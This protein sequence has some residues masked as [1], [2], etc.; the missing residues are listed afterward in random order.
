MT[1]VFDAA[2]IGGGLA[3]CS[4]AITLAQ[5]GA[6]VLLLEAK[7]YPLHRVC[8]EF[9][10]PASANILSELGVLP[11]VEALHPALIDRAR[12]VAP[13]GF[14]WEADL[15]GAGLGL[16]RYALDALL[17]HEAERLGVCLHTETTVQDVEGDL[18][19]GFTLTARHDGQI[20][21]YQARVVIAAYGKRA[22]LD[23]VLNRPFLHR[24]IQYVGLK[25]HLRG[26][27]IE[28]RVELYPFPGGYC[29]L[30]Q[31]E[32]GCT[33]VC[34]LVRQDV[35]Q[36]QGAGDISAFIEWMSGQNPALGAWLARAEVVHP[37]WF[38][39][40]QISFQR[41]AALEGDLLMTGD[42]AG[43]I[44]PLAGDG[45]EMA[46]HGGRMA[47]LMAAQFVHE[48]WSA[49][50][51][52]TQYPKAWRQTFGGRLSLARGL[53]T[54]MLRPALLPV[55]L[56][57]LHRSPALSQFVIRHTRNAA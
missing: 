56:R 8:G 30:S 27:S 23:R 36:R 11:Q 37:R 45:M 6:N 13:D 5:H 12:I 14:C 33:N 19:N 55:G 9:L 38:S 16:T 20:Q 48:R 49:A 26:I 53:Q 21:T 28:N 54:L 3:G 40:S 24:G 42:S 10:S 57:A 22:N 29:G 31:V 1:Q 46:L 34:L 32:D 2:I 52:R 35:F 47:G 41:K 4:A 50:Q 51:L 25:N 18:D 39:I 43:L 7:A 15:P 17:A 44:A